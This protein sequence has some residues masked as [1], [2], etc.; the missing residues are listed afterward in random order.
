MNNIF[1]SSI[2]NG[3]GKTFISA[4]IAAVMQSFGY[5][6]GVYKPIQIGALKKG[7]YLLSPDLKF[8]KLLDPY[9]IT[10]STYMINEKVSPAVICEE[11]KL[12]INLEE[13]NSD[14]K[15]LSKKTDTL[16]VESTGGLMMP[17]NKALFN[18]HIPLELKLPVAFIVNPSNDNVNHY[19]NEIN[20]AKTIGINIL[21]VIIN[22]FSVYSESKE[23][24]SFPT[25]IEQYSDAKVLG[26]IRNFKGKSV[27]SSALINEILNGIDLE[28]L[29]RMKISKLN[30]F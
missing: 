30:F 7:D 20:T 17:L 8:V 19:L 9:I 11:E 10:H 3:D 24:K 15:L 12:D 18:Y 14:Y 6:T 27:N 5:K 29:F 22:K 1:I 26:L 4:G 28:D 16:I 13:I 23:I 2:N 21:G 25:L